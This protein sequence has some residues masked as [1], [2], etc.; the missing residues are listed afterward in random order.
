MENLTIDACRVNE[1]LKH[2]TDV[3]RDYADK[4]GKAL[5]AKIFSMCFGEC[6]LPRHDGCVSGIQKSPSM[7][8]IRLTDIHILGAF[9]HWPQ[10][11]LKL[12][13]MI[14]ALKERDDDPFFKNNRALIE[15]KIKDWKT[16]AKNKLR[17]L[18][19]K[20]DG[21][22][23]EN[24]RVQNSVPKESEPSDIYDDEDNS[25]ES[26]QEYVEL[27]KLDKELQIYLNLS[28]ENYSEWRNAQ[29]VPDHNTESNYFRLFWR[30]HQI[31]M[32]LLS[33]IALKVNYPDKIAAKD[34]L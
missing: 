31:H 6:W 1:T 8:P 17:L 5:A 26:P 13:R 2:E 28:K 4:L 27:S 32:P 21:S 20:I 3:V 9:L 16:I 14:K 12:H 18:S 33:R 30:Y 19:E 7:E 11:N 25:Q 29:P 10:R 34:V 24:V 22:S 15:T 23:N